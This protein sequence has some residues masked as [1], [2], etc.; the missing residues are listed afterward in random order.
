MDGIY[1]GQKE[2]DGDEY[3]V[4]SIEGQRGAFK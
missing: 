3:N 4:E 1:E 2:V